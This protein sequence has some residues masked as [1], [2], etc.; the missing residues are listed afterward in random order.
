MKITIIQAYTKKK[1]PSNVAALLIRYFQKTDYSH[2][3]IKVID[4][5]TDVATYYDSTG[6]GTRKRTHEE[7]FKDYY[8]VREFNVPKTISYVDWLEFWARHANKGY[9]FKQVAGLLLK[10]FH[11]V[12]HNPFGAG[13]KRII[14]NELVILLL[15]YLGYTAIKDTDSLDLND[16]DRLLFKVLVDEK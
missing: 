14:C 16:T 2:Y 9:G 13:A 3:A 11:I 1:F 15:N 8:I 7:F 5:S 12:K 6:H 10:I 4:P